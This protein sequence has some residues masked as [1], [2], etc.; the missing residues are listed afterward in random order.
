[1]SPETTEE[2]AAGYSRR[3][4]LGRAGA[5]A[6]ALAAGSTFGGI[7]A[8][9][10]RS[11]FAQTSPTVFGRMFPDLGPANAATNRVR[12]ALR[13]IGK[14]G[15]P[16]D[17]QDN[18]AAGPVD[19]IVDPALSA[20]NANNP[21]HTAGTTFMGQF[22]DHD[23]TFD[24]TSRLGVTT[25]PERTRERTDAF[26]RPGLGLRQRAERV[27]SALRLARPRQAADL[28]RRPLRGP[29]AHI[30]ERGDHRRPAQRREPD[31]RRPAGRVH[32]V[33]QQRRSTTFAREDRWIST[34]RAFAEARRLTTWH[35]HWLIVKE[36]LP[37]FVGQARVDSVLRNRRF[38][39]PR[40]GEAFIPVE[41]Q[42]ACYRFGHSMVRPSYR[43]N[44]TG[45]TTARRSSG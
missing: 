37:L 22:L 39:R 13:D 33:P 7:F 12:D 23:M 32:Q 19:L 29:A 8:P 2:I 31:D 27:L 26:A 28:E 11:Q 6:G 14:L 30:V 43:A 40:T 10:A 45:D 1:M 44:L 34:S 16:L 17:A 36:F 5:G 15:G 20:N 4:F 38:Y 24:T 18:L 35:Y 9:A 41:F 21:T 42:G 25:A 3:N